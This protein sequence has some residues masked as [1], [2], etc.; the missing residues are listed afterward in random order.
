M[1]CGRALCIIVRGK[2]LLLVQRNDGEMNVIDRAKVVKN[3]RRPSF[4]F[5]RLLIGYIYRNSRTD[6][7]L[8]FWRRLASPTLH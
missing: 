7:R 2:K 1:V 8:A 4:K 3:I 6:Y 5:E